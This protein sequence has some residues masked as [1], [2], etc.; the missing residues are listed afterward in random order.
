MFIYLYGNVVFGQYDFVDVGIG[1]GFFLL[2]LFQFGCCEIVW[3]VEQVFQGVFLFY[4]FKV[5]L[6]GSYC[7]VVILDNGRVYY[8]LLFV[9]K[10]QAVYLVGYIDVVNCCFGYVGLFQ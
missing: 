8:L 7:L 9:Y 5:S 6:F 3:I 1:V 10:D 4:G 2:Y